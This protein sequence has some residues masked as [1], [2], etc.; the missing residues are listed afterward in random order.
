MHLAVLLHLEKVKT[1]GGVCWQ[2]WPRGC[3][4]WHVVACAAGMSRLGGGN[5]LPRHVSVC[6]HVQAD[7]AMLHASVCSHL[8]PC[9]RTRPNAL[10]WHLAGLGCPWQH[11][12]A[13]VGKAHG[14]MW[15]QLAAP[16]SRL[17][18]QHGQLCLGRP[19][20]VG[21]CQAQA[22]HACSC[23]QAR[24]GQAMCG[25]LPVHAFN[26]QPLHCHKSSHTVIS[27]CKNLLESYQHVQQ[28]HSGYL[29]NARTQP[30]AALHAAA[31]V[32][33]TGQRRRIQQ[34]NTIALAPTPNLQL[35]ETCCPH[36]L[37]TPYS[38]SGHLSCHIRSCHTCLHHR[39]I[40]CLLRS[41]RS[42]L[43]PPPPWP[44]QMARQLPC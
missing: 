29:A 33:A 3:T 13:A 26:C 16:A 42:H 10:A 8:A 25:R 17:G 9:H 11:G 7:T 18:R 1:G 20:H 32:A 39:R 2:A 40:C 43:H 34:P 31:A 21:A 38:H 22:S 35:S 24:P 37:G 4:R 6:L 36:H 15:P 5:H 19:V 41:R 12:V 44:R 14:P 27:Q 23:T 30:F 28:W